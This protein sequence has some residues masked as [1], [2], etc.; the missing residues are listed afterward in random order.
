MQD[1][2]YKMKR[3]ARFIAC[4]VGVLLVAATVGALAFSLA[5]TDVGADSSLKMT[6]LSV[7]QE[8]S[9]VLQENDRKPVQFTVQVDGKT[10]PILTQ[11]DTVSGALEEYGIQVGS[12]DQLTGAE[13]DSVPVSGMSVTLVRVTTGTVQETKTLWSQTKYVLD[14]SLTAGTYVTRNPGKNG[15]VVYTYEVVYRDGEVVS[16]TLVDTVRTEAVDQVIA[17]NEKQSFSNSRGQQITYSTAIEGI[18]TAYIPDGKWGYTTYTGNRARPGVIAVDPN[19][20]PLG[21]K[22]YVQSHNSQFGDYGYAIAWDIGGSIK[23]NKIDL[24]MESYDL[25]MQWGVRDVTIYILED[26]SVDVF[27]LRQ[28]NEVFIS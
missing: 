22:V 17:Y 20:I 28:G 4:C 18:A 5:I 14:K 15:S 27:S 13:A 24:F 12:Q 23:G 6:V 19:V 10:Y 9:G 21:T 11:S 7:T 3:I 2:S 8:A 25:S 1:F 26:Q 16:K